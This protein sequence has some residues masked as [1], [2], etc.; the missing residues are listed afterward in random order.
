MEET[1][2]TVSNRTRKTLE[3]RDENGQDEKRLS[4]EL[5]CHTI[6]IGFAVEELCYSR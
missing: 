5:L 3:S 1:K 2:K 6:Q 4:R